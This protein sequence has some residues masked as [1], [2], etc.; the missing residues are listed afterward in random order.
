MRDRYGRDQADAW[1]S[2]VGTHIITRM[3]LG[4]TAEEVCRLIST[5][6]VE[7]QSRNRTYSRGDVSVNE[8]TRL[9]TKE[10]ITVDELQSRLGPKKRGIRALMLGPGKDVYEFTVPYVTLP[11]YR[12]ASQPKTADPPALDRPV[13][14]KPAGLLSKDAVRKI[15]DRG[16]G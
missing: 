11:N 15:K 12:P 13:D 14:R 16:A 10:V 3:T 7:A 5:Q 2:M 1:I 6:K 8:G 9:E 4:R